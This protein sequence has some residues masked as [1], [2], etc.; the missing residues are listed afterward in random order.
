MSKNVEIKPR[1][2]NKFCTN[3]S[4]RP[5]TETDKT[6]EWMDKTNEWASES[7]CMH[8]QFVGIEIKLAIM[9][10]E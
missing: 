10:I 2:G 3:I 1:N 7:S 6:N 5:L 8:V 4:L 9:N